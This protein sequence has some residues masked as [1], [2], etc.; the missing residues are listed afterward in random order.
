MINLILKD[1]LNHFEIDADL[2]DYLL[3]QTFNEVFMDGNL[4]V[5]DN[6]FKI[7]VK[8]R[9]DVVHQMYIEPDGEFPVIILSELPSGLSNG[10]KFP[11]TES[12]GIPIDG[13]DM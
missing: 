7:V 4:S 3:S 2:P 9:Q 5:E 6:I 1:L 12:V 11:K 10:M 13:L 8:T